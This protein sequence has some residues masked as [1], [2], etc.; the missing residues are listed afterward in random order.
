M[1]TATAGAARSRRRAGGELLLRVFACSRT[2]L[3]QTLTGLLGK[4]ED[5]QDALQDAF[6]KCWRRRDQVGRIRNLRAWV[7]RVAVNA[8]RD[9]RRNAWCRKARPLP[10]QLLLPDL[11][12]PPPCDQVLDREALD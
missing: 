3:L 8:A 9:L 7:Y 12:S 6:L 10:A 2:E 11:T 4:P 1:P 5:A